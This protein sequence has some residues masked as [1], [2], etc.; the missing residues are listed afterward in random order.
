M[1]GSMVSFP[2]NGTTTP[3]TSRR[4]GAAPGPG[5]WSSRNGGGSSRTSSTSAT[6]S[7]PRA[8]WRWRRTCTTAR[9]RASPTA[10]ANCSWRSTSPAPK[11]TS[12][13]AAKH[14]LAHSSSKKIGAVGFCMGGQL[15]LF[16]ATLNPTVGACV[17]FYGIHPNVVKP[18]Y[19]RSWRARARTLRRRRTAS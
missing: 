7:P 14:L 13:G 17:N 2:T 11:R 15:A 18:D 19:C 6:A 4:L 8:S 1:T 12:R 16:A 5:S 10:P 3:D 9:R